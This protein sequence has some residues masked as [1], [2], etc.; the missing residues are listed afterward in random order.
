M[1][2]NVELLDTV[3]VR[4]DLPEVGLSAGEV[5]AV[6][7]VLSPDAFEVEFVD[8]AGQTY[9]LHTL[10]RDQLMPPHQRGRTLRLRAEVA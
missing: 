5:G 10:K 2:Q 8:Q 7:A 4:E 6:V 9:A 3:A 1:S